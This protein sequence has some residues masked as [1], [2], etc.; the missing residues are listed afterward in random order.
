M[1]NYME[2]RCGA[3]AVATPGN[4]NAWETM[5]K[6]YGK[7]GWRRFFDAAIELADGGFV[8]GNITAGWIDAAFPE[9]PDNAKSI[10]GNNGVPVRAGERLVPKDLARSFRFIADQGTGAMYGGELG[11]TIDSAMR[12]NGGFL[13]IDDL[14]NNRAQWRGTISIDQRGYEVTTASPPATSWNASSGWE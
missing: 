2:N 10:Y 12:K 13:T 4:L 9:F 14:R 3:K 5:S 11:Q 8:L 7:L 6:D 1:P